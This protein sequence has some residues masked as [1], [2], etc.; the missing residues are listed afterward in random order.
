MLVTSLITILVANGPGPE[1]REF[2]GE[3]ALG[4]LQSFHEMQ[5]LVLEP[6]LPG[7]HDARAGRERVRVKGRRTVTTEHATAIAAIFLRDRTYRFDRSKDCNFIPKSGLRLTNGFHRLDLL[8]S[9][10]CNTFRM[11]LFDDQGQLLMRKEEDFDRSKRKL[12]RLLRRALKAEP[13]T[14]VVAAN[15]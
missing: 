6:P 12:R 5:I 7:E 2:L 10:E 3:D 15:E 14:N 4:V 1:V 11:V 9:F 8:L 13:E